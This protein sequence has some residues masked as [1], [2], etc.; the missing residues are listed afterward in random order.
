M[1]Q[2]F[3]SLLAA[4]L[5][6][7]LAASAPLAAWAQQAV[8]PSERVTRNVV[9]RAAPDTT[10]PALDRL[11]PG[12]AAPLIADAPGWYRI[13]LPDGQEGFVSKAWTDLAGAPLAAVGKS[14]KVHVID[15]GTGLAVFVQG[16]D[17][18]LLYDA[19]SQDD[20]AKG[21]DNRVV[22]YIKAVAP[23][24]RVLNHVILSH[25]HKD[26]LELMPEVFDTFQVENVWESGR[27]NPTAGYCRFLQKVVAEHAIYHDAIASNAVRTAAFKEGK[28]K[29]GVRLSEG[30]MMTAAPIRL[31]D[32]AQ[33]TLLYRDA[34]NYDDPNGNSVVTRLDL[35]DR[36]ILLAGDAEGGDRPAPGDAEGAERVAHTAQPK[37]NSI[38]AK[39]LDACCRAQLAADLL[40]VGHHGSL[41]SSRGAFLDAVGAKLFVISSGPHPYQSVVLPDPA[42][43]KMLKARGTLYRTDRDD[44]ACETEPAKPG[45]DADE[46]PGGCDNVL[47]TI[48]PSA[49]LKVDYVKPVD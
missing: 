16:D 35:G 20:L 40:V 18:A 7:A 15:V 32:Q 23:N 47:I 38:E 31:G 13:R 30:P 5:A 2:T 4:V 37:A 42:V 6:L 43:V 46:S 48:Q 26:H 33:M 34:F 45:P 14:F 10:S 1:M 19:G 25:P 9:V 41:T 8:T 36:R 17:F 24:L 12:D 44:G 22:A 39:L 29:D 11:L 21:A 28:C 49:P 27:V 3:R